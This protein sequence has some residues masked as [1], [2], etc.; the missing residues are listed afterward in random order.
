MSV[1]KTIT[2]CPNYEVSDAGEVR[3]VVTGRKRKNCYRNGYSVVTLHKGSYEYL[4]FKIHRLVAL[5]FIENPENK[6]MVDHIDRDKTNNHI[7]NLRWVT[8]S[9][10]MKNTD[11]RIQKTD[12]SH[13]IRE[14]EYGTF[15]VRFTTTHKR[16]IKTFKTL[17][18]A[19]A[20]R[21]QFMIDNP[22]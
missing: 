19:I 6:P 14:T 10:N 5:H 9:E 4:S 3:H 18:E 21:D 13:F 12:G 1:W 7:S 16:L 15:C 8:C 11:F 17:E 22:R 2:E 20:F